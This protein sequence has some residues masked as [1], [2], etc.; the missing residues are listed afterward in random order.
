MSSATKSVLLVLGFLMLVF[1]GCC[2]SIQARS[3]MRR[4]EFEQTAD[5]LGFEPTVNGVAEYMGQSIEIG[6]TRDEVELI[7]SDIAP[8]SVEQGDLNADSRAGWGPIAC[9]RIWL[10]L[11]A[12]VT[13][14]PVPLVACYDAQGGLVAMDFAEPDMTPLD[15]SAPR[16]E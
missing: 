12:V 10:D 16:R 9:D 2:G 14:G 13:G 15:I 6:M 1:L 5:S 3:E 7:L 11:G 4:L 8:L